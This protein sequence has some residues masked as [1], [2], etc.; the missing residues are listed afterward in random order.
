VHVTGNPSPSLVRRFLPFILILII[1]PLLGCNLLNRFS[2][3]GGTEAEMSLE[4]ALQVEPVDS[5]PEVMEE[6]GPP[7]AFTIT[8][9]ELEGQIVRWDS[10]SYFDFLAQFDFIDGELIWSVEL[11]P[12]ADGSLYAHW[13]DPLD[14]QPG[15]SVAEVQA[16]YPEVDFLE[17]DLTEV[18][19]EGSLALAG[20][21]II[22]AFD[23]DRLVYVETVILSPDPDGT[24]L[25]IP[26]GDLNMDQGSINNT[27]GA[28]GEEETLSYLNDSF[29]SEEPFPIPID[30]EDFMTFENLNGQ[31]VFTS[32]LEQ[33]LMIAFYED[34]NPP[35]FILEVDITFQNPGIGTKAGV[36]FRGEDPIDG[37]NHYIHIAV[38]PVEK[39]I[40]LSVYNQKEWKRWDLIDIPQDLINPDGIYHL[41]VESIGSGSV[42]M[43]DGVQ[44]ALLRDEEVIYP[45]VFGL[46]LAAY[47]VPETVYF[48][49]LSIIE[50]PGQ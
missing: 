27:S 4:E 25:E 34:F 43:L 8:F 33:K 23:Q 40:V 26:A 36:I 1:I 6:M 14:F 21:Q 28:E 35:D 12:V 29:D 30:I 41:G 7:D 37:M 50:H 3:E 9:T 22:L 44:I 13:Y 46:S 32:N 2:S 24:P 39:K 49:N 10:W 11:E 5:R 38:A 31:G 18:D 42:V 48:D 20:E 16:L 19:L 17:L 47:E 45:G 15:M